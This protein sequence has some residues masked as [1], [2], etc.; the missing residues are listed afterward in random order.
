LLLPSELILALLDL[1]LDLLVLIPN[2]GQLVSDVVELFLERCELLVDHY[3]FVVLLLFLSLELVSLSLLSME[4]LLLFLKLLSLL[5]CCFHDLV[6]DKHL[7]FHFLQ[8]LHELL[9]LGLRLLLRLF[10]VS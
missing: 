7:L 4:N 6:A 3:Q 2:L 10:F 9:L 5:S 8:L 1:T